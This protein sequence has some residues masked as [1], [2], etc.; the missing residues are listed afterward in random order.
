MNLTM[1]VLPFRS[2]VEFGTP[3]VLHE[4]SMTEIFDGT[5]RK[6]RQTQFL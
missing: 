6:P 2:V 4:K 1:S 3:D 5:P